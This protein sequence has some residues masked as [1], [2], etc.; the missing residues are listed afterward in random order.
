MAGVHV[1]QIKIPDRPQFP[2][3]WRRLYGL[4]SSQLTKQGSVAPPVCRQWPWCSHA[5]EEVGA[6]EQ[7]SELRTPPDLP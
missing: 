4:K 2:K 5:D 6:E 7:S 1:F 3:L